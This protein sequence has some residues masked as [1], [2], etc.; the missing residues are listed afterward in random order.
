MNRIKKIITSLAMVIGV[1]LPSMAHNFEVDGIYYNVLSGTDK[2]VEV[3]YKGSS[4]SSYSNEYSGDVVIPETVTYYGTT[5][6][7]TGID[8]NTF[9]S[10]QYLISVRI[11]KTIECIGSEAFR[12]S[13]S[14]LR[15]YVYCAPP[16][17]DDYWSL[18]VTNNYGYIYPTIYV[19][20]NYINEYNT[21]AY[22]S[23]IPTYTMSMSK[24]LDEIIDTD[25][26][27]TTTISFSGTGTGTE[28]DP[29]K[30]YNPVQLN[31]V[32]NSV[33][34]TGI[35]YKLMNDIDMT[36][37][38]AENNPTEGWQ[39]IGNKSAMFKGI[40]IGN[41]NKI[42]GLT[43]NRETTEYV[44]LFGYASNATISDLE[45]EGTVIGGNYT[46]GLIG[47]SQNSTITNCT[48]NGSVSGD[49]YTG[50]IVGSAYTS[51]YT[52]SEHNGLVTGKSDITGG[53]VGELFRSTFDS[54]NHIGDVHG[55]DFVGGFSGN[56]I[57]WPNV[58]IYG[59]PYPSLSYPDPGYINLEFDG[60]NLITNNDV[61]GKIS[62]HNYV[63]GFIGASAVTY[64]P[65]K[66][67]IFTNYYNCDIITDLT[68]SNC[69]HTGN[70]EGASNVGGFVGRN[71]V[72][73]DETAT[74][75]NSTL[76][77][78]ASYSNCSHF[79][80]IS[81][82]E[83]VGGFIGHAAGYHEGT[84]SLSISNCHSISDI[85]SNGNYA[86]G[87]IGASTSAT[88]Q[89]PVTIADCYYNGNIIGDDYVGG[90]IGS[91]EYSSISNS[92]VN[93]ALVSGNSNVGGIAGYVDATSGIASS[94]SI[95]EKV[96]A[97]KENVGRIYG[98]IASGTTI[99]EM[100]T[101]LENKGLATAT[102]NLNGVQQTLSD[103][104]Q[105]GTNIGKSTLKIR[106]TYQGIGWDFTSNWSNQETESY[107]YKPTQT[108]PPVIVSTATA[109][110][111]IVSGKA[112]SNAVVTVEVSG[113]TY[114]TTAAGNQWSI[115]VDPLQSGATISVYS[116]SENLS[117][118]YKVYQ[119]VAYQGSGTADDPYLIYTADDLASVNGTGYYKL[120]SDI[121][122][123][124]WIAENNPEGGWLPLGRTGSVMSHLIGNGKTIS[125]L[126]C[127]SESPQTALIAVAENISISDLTIKIADNKTIE[128]AD[129][130]AILVSQAENCTLTN[131]HVS[132]NISG[133]SFVG[134]LVGLAQSGSIDN[135]TSNVTINATGN[136]SG[137]LIGDAKALTITNSYSTATISSGNYIGGLAGNSAGDIS[138]SF[139][140]ATITGANMTEDNIGYAGGL[141]GFMSAN[142]SMSYSKGSVS[143][144]NVGTECYVGGLVG[145]NAGG[146]ISNCYSVATTS[147][148]QYAAGIAGYNTGQISYCY[149]TGD[150]SAY[151]Y[152]AG[153]VGY[154]DGANALTTNCVAA[155]NILAVSDET[156]IAM[157]VIGGTRNGASE[158]E[159]NNYAL[160]S[161]AVSVNDIAQ[162]IYDDPMHGIG[163]TQTEL[164]QA[165]TYTDLEW[166]MSNI[167]GI[168]EGSEYPYLLLSPDEIVKATSISI[169]Q[170]QST[171]VV[172]NTI[173]LVAKV[174]PDDTTLKTVAWSSSDENIATVTDEGVV[175][176]VSV[177]EVV[178]SATTTDGSNLSATCNVSVIEKVVNYLTASD[179]SVQKGGTYSLPIELINENDITAFQCDIYLPEGISIA[180]VDEEYDITLSSRS[181]SSHIIASALQTDG[182][183][184]VLSYTTLMKSYSGNSGELFGVTLNISSDYNGDGK[185]KIANIV[186]TSPTEVEYTSPDFELSVGLLDYIPGDTNS[187]LRVNVTDVARTANYVLG[188]APAD[189]VF[190]AA[191]VS[192]DGK[193]NVS[194]IAGISN[195]ILNGSTTAT[196]ATMSTMAVRSLGELSLNDVVIAA[197][198]TKALDIY[199][200]NA[201][202]YTAFQ[203]DINLPNG[204]N[205]SNAR[206]S[207]EA[208]SSHNLIW[209]EQENGAVRFLSFSLENTPIDSENGVLLTLELNADYG[210]IGGNIDIE[211]IVFVG[212]D[213]TENI[214]RN[215]SATT[216]YPSGIN[217]V[218]G[219][220]LVTVENHTINI[221]SASAGQ[222]TLVSVSGISKSFDIECGHNEIS[223]ANNG[224]Y[225]LIVNNDQY[226][227]IIK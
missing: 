69:T 188:N 57:I 139:A 87:V 136:Y 210:F 4:S 34:H 140:T 215:V 145:Y 148:T 142:I 76:S 39:P 177:G 179:I 221:E 92:Y 33:G 114:T 146:N 208:V 219:E 151:L 227:L 52:Q 189:F 110:G 213:L 118:S 158:P 198:E 46:G 18:A 16:E 8:D 73:T 27:L 200:A 117:E 115:T 40:F 127:K 162:K 214:F 112:E 211:N 10:C 173:T 41:G 22:W 154:N 128:G 2:T 75:T 71:E 55:L 108:A 72:G 121:D 216:I 53:F 95:V 141:V 119:I 143:F 58:E 106:S 120:M 207:S 196:S 123:S 124:E 186:M 226:K 38:I 125:G 202:L 94:V 197:G 122:L 109:N 26:E 217:N 159:L 176:A 56:S 29:Y 174:S 67:V 93:S 21:F 167:W 135:C 138:T 155:N 181:T 25:N 134:G 105:H 81:G 36:E 178:I 168:K 99:G 222:A 60:F 5:Y 220:T 184:R 161:M 163:K 66:N 193:I 156:G 150:V 48:F 116:K 185:I 102:V 19:L 113:K 45:V 204:M 130:T 149:A 89:Y 100:G 77:A 131:C 137:G 111:T 90:I 103:G 126:W 206:L 101:N 12:A 37:W 192:G 24:I 195:I 153:V 199:I 83:Y 107:P 11:P 132:G 49:S 171:I 14:S 68:I 194:D 42:T 85:T 1:A 84:R 74:I 28:N 65:T 209:E 91:G 183:I 97:T 6:T 82:K 98:S 3:T 35:Y 152:G 172:G 54:C 32:R 201:S 165:S 7:V 224:V 205:I 62:G 190:E 223:V 160:A 169:D 80:S 9:S 147:S 88:T 157:R 31:D 212:T 164:L 86:G 191:D 203:M 17:I 182:A 166:D 50:G 30:I 78:K 70:V 23:Q 133:G 43:I 51:T 47:R 175:T 180:E 15:L 218:V 64:S 61:S 79:G 187:D 44:G 63:G 96:S 144:D 13:N 225:I 59:Y 104:P 20:P 129:Y 170:A